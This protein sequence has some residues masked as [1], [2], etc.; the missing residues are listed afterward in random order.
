MSVLPGIIGTGDWS[1][2]DYPENWRTTLLRLRPNAKSVLTMLMGLAKTE[3]TD[4][5]NYH[6]G[7]KGIRQMV[8]ASGAATSTATTIVFTGTTPLKPIRNGHVLRNTRSQ[9]VV[10]VDA[11]PS[12]PYTDLSCIRGDSCGSTS[13]A[14]NAADNWILVTTRHE[15]NATPPQ[16]NYRTP[17]WIENYTEIF[18]N[19]ISLS[20]TTKKTALR[21]AKEGPTKEM[22]HDA[23]EDHMIDIESA[24]I[25]GVPYEGTGADGLPER[26]TGG[27]L[28]YCT[29]SGTD[30]GGSFSLLDFLDALRIAMRYGSNTKLCLMGDQALL[31]LMH[32]VLSNSSFQVDANTKMWG[33]NVL[34][35]LSPFGTLMVKQHELLTDSED[36]SDWAL[37]IDTKNVR[38]RPLRESDTKL[39]PN[40]VKDGRDGEISEYL[41]EG[42]WEWDLEQ[43]HAVWEN[44][45][46]FSTS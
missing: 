15:E 26:T 6:W 28:H 24:G 22:L 10:W 41:G 16:G 1:A 18:R 9:E 11:D 14:V 29:T 46:G 44:F 19:V 23:L 38:Y 13:A 35:I 36:Y 40:A 42:G 34:R 31:T 37:I 7:E 3:E 4:A 39:I 20:R 33:M 27:M 5:P 21:Y 2:D 12:S 30:F 17:T 8:F 32:F 45:A 25:W 43:T